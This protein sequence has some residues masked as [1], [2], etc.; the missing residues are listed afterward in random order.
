MWLWRLASP[1]SV[2]LMSQFRSKGWKTQEELMRQLK[3]FRQ[4]AFYP[5]CGEVRLLFYLCLQLIRWGPP[6]SGRAICFT[7]SVDLNV[8]L[9]QKCPNG[10]TQNNVWLYIQALHGPAKLTHHINHHRKSVC[11]SSLYIPC[12]GLRMKPAS[13]SFRFLICKGGAVSSRGANESMTLMPL[14][15]A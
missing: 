15:G 8:N 12:K 9:I 4:E 3:I 13:L 2:E 7:Q 11:G 10:N 14:W 1:N 6:T 5:N